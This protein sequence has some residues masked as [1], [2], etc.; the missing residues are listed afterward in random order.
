MFCKVLIA[1]ADTELFFLYKIYTYA[2]SDSPRT[3][4]SC[5]TWIS[6]ESAEF[7]IFQS[8][9]GAAPGSELAVFKGVFLSYPSLC[10]A[11]YVPLCLG[12]MIAFF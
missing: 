4:V 6:L 5:T 10:S 2:L 8:V 11:N 9:H 1:M 7:H 12:A 3:S